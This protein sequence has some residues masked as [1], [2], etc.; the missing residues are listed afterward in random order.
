MECGERTFGTKNPFQCENCKAQTYDNPTPVAVLLVPAQDSDGRIGA[1]MTKRSIAPGL[2]QWCL[3]SGHIEGKETAEQTMARELLEETGFVVKPED[4]T[5][6]HTFN[7]ENGR[8][9]IFGEANFDS[10]IR[11]HELR[12]FKPTDE[13]SEVCVAPADGNLD[14]CFPSHHEYLMRP[15]RHFG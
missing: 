5:L 15:R 6:S 1:L 10:L 13:A 11:N 7:T 4:I 9:L 12:R 2:G 3:V 14:I 8:L